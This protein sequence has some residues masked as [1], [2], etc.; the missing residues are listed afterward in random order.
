MAIADSSIWL[1]Y[2]ENDKTKYA[3][4]LETLIKGDKIVIC[5]YTIAKIL[6][7]IKDKEA[8]ENLLKG[9]LALPY[10]E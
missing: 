8:L 3:F 6:K 1:D 4:L 2:F 5:G 7:D 9:F 10:V